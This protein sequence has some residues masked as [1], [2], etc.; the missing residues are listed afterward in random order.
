METRAPGSSCLPFL[1][2]QPPHSDLSTANVACALQGTRS[3]TAGPKQSQERARAAP[4]RGVGAWGQQGHASGWPQ[5]ADTQGGDFKHARADIA[6]A[7]PQFWTLQ[8]S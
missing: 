1:V 8:P 3:L 6:L 2:L 5:N 7:F 4:G